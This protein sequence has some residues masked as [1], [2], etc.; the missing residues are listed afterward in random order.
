[1]TTEQPD[2][3][4]ENQLS[5][6]RS[7]AS[8]HSAESILAGIGREARAKQRQVVGSVC[9]ALVSVIAA[10]FFVMRGDPI[11]YVALPFTALV[12]G[13][14]AYRAASSVQALGQLSSGR[15]L[16]DSWR[17]ELQIKL[18]QTRHGV[19]IAAMFGVLTAWVMARH[20]IVSGRGLFYG[21]TAVLIGAFVGYQ[22]LVVRPRLQRELQSLNGDA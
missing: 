11:G 16:L 17:A 13:F 20:G 10:A 6:L 22:W 2:Q 15:D 9:G 3:A 19:V 18:K 8:R 7:L 5:Q 21:I 14:V 1:M 12:F 4:L